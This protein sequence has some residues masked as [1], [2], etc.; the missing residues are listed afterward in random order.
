M[1][2]PHILF[3]AARWWSAAFCTCAVPFLAR[4]AEVVKLASIVSAQP[5]HVGA[6]VEAAPGPTPHR[7]NVSPLLRHHLRQVLK[8]GIH[9]HNIALDALD[10]FLLLFDHSLVEGELP[11][12]LLTPG[13]GWE[14]ERNGA[15][16]RCGGDRCPCTYCSRPADSSGEPDSL[17]ARGE[18][19]G[20]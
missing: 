11:L 17:R 5:V 15:V 2:R 1:S 18:G 4:S 16:R 14:G 13:C 20:W 3:L 10:V 9:L 7:T 12:Q 19:T 8:Q 6:R